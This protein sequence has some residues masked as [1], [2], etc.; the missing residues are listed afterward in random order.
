MIESEH[1]DSTLPIFRDG[2]AGTSS[3]LWGQQKDVQ[4]EQTQEKHYI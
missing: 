1:C 3:L 4:D 2:A